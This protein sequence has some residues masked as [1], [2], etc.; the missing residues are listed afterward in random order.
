MNSFKKRLHHDAEQILVVKTQNPGSM[1]ACAS[2]Q[3]GKHPEAFRIE[4]R[5][6][7][8][9]LGSN[10]SV[11]GV[12]FEKYREGKPH[13]QFQPRPWKAFLVVD[14]FPLRLQPDLRC[15]HHLPGNGPARIRRRCDAPPMLEAPEDPKS[16]FANSPFARF[17]G[18][19]VG[20]DDVLFMPFSPKIIPFFPLF[21]AA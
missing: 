15:L 6:D 18:I 3:S 8:V 16:V 14:S 4:S 7:A 20:N 9:T 11:A 2:S 12:R 5:C 13:V 19:R 1:K 21:T 10:I 17:L